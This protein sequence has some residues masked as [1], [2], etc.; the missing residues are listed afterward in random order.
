MRTT[1][2]AAI[3]LPLLLSTPA[4]AQEVCGLPARLTPAYALAM[5]GAFQSSCQKTGCTVIGR[6]VERHRVMLARKTDK[7]AWQIWLTLA[8]RAD[9]SEGVEFIIDGG[10]PQRIPPEFLIDTGGGVSVRIDEKLSD[11]VL[12]MLDGGKALTIAYA[13]RQGDKRRVT[14]SLEGLKKM[15]DWSNCALNKLNG[16]GK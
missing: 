6:T 5:H 16:S 8:G 1:F 12:E 9:V 4:G 3:A 14:L 2:A 10:E 11:V 13:T 7:A 15:R